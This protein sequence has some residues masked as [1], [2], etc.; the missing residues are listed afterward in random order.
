MGISE[1]HYAGESSTIQKREQDKIKT[2]NLQ[3]VMV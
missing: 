3:N 1:I 2:D